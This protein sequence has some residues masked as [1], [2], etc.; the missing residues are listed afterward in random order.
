[1][2]EKLDF[3]KSV[4]YITR[5]EQKLNFILIF[6]IFNISVV[7]EKFLEYIFLIKNYILKIFY[8]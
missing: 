7:N 5:S 2:K 6:K 8:F 4:F 1:M 3:Y